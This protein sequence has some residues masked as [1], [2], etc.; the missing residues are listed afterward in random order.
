MSLFDRLKCGETAKLC[1]SWPCRP[2]LLPLSLAS[3][4][5][6]N[7]VL[8]NPWSVLIMTMHGSGSSTHGIGQAT[9]AQHHARTCQARGERALD[10]P[11]R[12]ALDRPRPSPASLC[13]QR[14][15]PPSPLPRRH[16]R[17]PAAALSP[18]SSSERCRGYCR[19]RIKLLS[20]P[21]VLSPRQL[22]LEH[23]HNAAYKMPSS[24]CPFDRRR[25][26]AMLAPSQH[27]RHPLGTINR[28]APSM[29]SSH[30]STLL[31]SLIPLTTLV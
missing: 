19:T 3:L 28:G 22:L 29:I 9:R 1:Q 16:A 2:P 30:Q 8:E 25:R 14:E 21:V 15:P 13:L 11:V 7:H 4:T 17:A 10:T 12:R 23:R 5:Q 20:D 27:P 31:S 18:S 26:R 24:P 6:P